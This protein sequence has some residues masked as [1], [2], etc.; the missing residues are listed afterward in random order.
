MFGSSLVPQG[1]CNDFPLVTVPKKDKRRR[2]NKHDGSAGSS[3][4]IICCQRR[5]RKNFFNVRHPEVFTT[6]RKISNIKKNNDAAGFFASRQRC[7]FVNIQETY[8]K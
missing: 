2:Q 5:K 6:L 3:S 7:S 8:A 1:Q 4:L